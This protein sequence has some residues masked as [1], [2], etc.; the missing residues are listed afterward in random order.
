VIGLDS[1]M[2]LNDYYHMS[3]IKQIAIWIGII[4]GGIGFFF[5]SIE[6]AEFM[7]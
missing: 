1:I 7:R 5:F 4:G 3:R 2:R 6:A